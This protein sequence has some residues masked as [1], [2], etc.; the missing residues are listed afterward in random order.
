VAELCLA[1]RREFPRFRLVAKEQ[2]AFMRRLYRLGLL[3][4]WN[5]RFMGGYTTTIGYVV[6]M[7]AAVRGD[8]RAGVDV[9]RHERIHLLQFQRH[10]LWFPLSYLLLLPCLVTFRARWEL[11]AYVESMR[12]EL[13]R[14]GRIADATLEHIQGRFTGPDYFFMDVR[15]G[16]V[17]RKLEAARDALLRGAGADPSRR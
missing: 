9:L 11:E 16:R 17:R 6:Y 13:E 4:L 1:L 15:R 12:V 5:P 8:A 14:E 7:P 10:P 2:S 3:A